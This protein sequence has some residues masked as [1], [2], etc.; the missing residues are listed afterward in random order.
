MKL[1]QIYL[2]N[3]ERSKDRLNHFM[4][5]VEKHQ[6]DKSKLTIFKAIDAKTH[7][8]TKEE[9]ELISNLKGLKSI[10]CNFLSHYYCWKDSI[11]KGYNYTLIVQDDVYFVNNI[12]KKLDDI[13]DHF[14]K[15][16][17][18]INI[19]LHLGANLSVFIDFPIHEEYERNYCKEMIND[20][21]CKWKEEVN[22]CSTSYIINCKNVD[23][24]FSKFKEISR[25]MDGFFNDYC[26]NKDIQYGSV[27]I[28]A[29]G[30]SNFKSTVF[31]GPT[32]SE[33]L[34]SYNSFINIK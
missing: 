24:L 17:E 6:I 27:D 8:F 14:P 10:Q 22:P 4:N 26:N 13:I 21:V 15:D 33:L 23:L 31:E 25:P 12:C 28:L 5:E 29:T 1:D 9:E 30:N 20:Y 11:E 32:F 34:E 18:I 16:A 2:I 19:G 7:E 3:L